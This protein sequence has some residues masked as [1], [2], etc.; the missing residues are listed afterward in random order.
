MDKLGHESLVTYTSLA[1]LRGGETKWLR[2]R[3][4]G[5][6]ALLTALLTI[7]VACL[8]WQAPMEL[9]VQR[10]PGSMFVVDGDGEIRNTFLVKVTNK[11]LT[12]ATFTV[13]VEDLP[14]SEVTVGNVSLAPSESTQ[15]PM[16]VRMHGDEAKKRTLPFNVTVRRDDGA[17]TSAKTTFKTDA[18]VQE[19]S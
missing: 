7:L 10:A 18:S 16:I 19:D 3:T 4:V 1:A 15:V 9:V 14:G 12:A 2:P 5:Y 13:T 6:A 8:A 17:T 11:S